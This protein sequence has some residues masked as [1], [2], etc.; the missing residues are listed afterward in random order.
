MSAKSIKNSKLASENSSICEYAYITRI[1]RV[2]RERS[3]VHPN[4]KSI[5][6]A[7]MHAWRLIMEYIVY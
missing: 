1:Y 4:I 7:T 2:V 5:T 6:A 3:L